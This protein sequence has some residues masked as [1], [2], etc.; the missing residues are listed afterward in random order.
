[1]K[2]NQGI[3]NDQTFI[4]DTNSDNPQIIAQA[5]INSVNHQLDT[6]APEIKIQLKPKTP[7]FLTPQTKLLIEDRDRAQQTTK[8]TQSVEDFRYFNN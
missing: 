4:T 5:I 6:Q 8:L 7:Q 3:N 2:V 1:M